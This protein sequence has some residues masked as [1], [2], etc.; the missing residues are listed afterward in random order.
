[1][2]APLANPTAVASNSSF[3]P[4]LQNMRRYNQLEGGGEGERIEDGGTSRQS[5]TVQQASN[6][7]TLI[8]ASMF[9]S[10]CRWQVPLL[11]HFDASPNPK[12]AL[13]LQPRAVTSKAVFANIHMTSMLTVYTVALV[14]LLMCV[15]CLAAM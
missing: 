1:M 14:A 12:P 8:L 15:S 5:D 13:L 9:M 2:Y 3:L 6:M 7:H 4:A 10:I 11:L